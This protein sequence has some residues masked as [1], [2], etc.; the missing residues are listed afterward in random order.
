VRQS[1]GYV[2]LQS[3]TGEGATFQVY[4]PLVRRRDK[5]PRRD[6]A[7]AKTHFAGNE[8]ILLVDDEDELREAVAE[9][10]EGR[11]YKVLKAKDGQEAVRLAERCDGKISLLISDVVMPK[12]NG[13][14]LVDYIRGAHQETAVLVVSGYAD[15]EALRQGL[16]RTASFLQK[17]FTLQLLGARVRELMDEKKASPS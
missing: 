13:R 14:M 6:E 11:G 9:Y 17:P 12:M 3:T 2:T 15:D 16:S 1:G 5:R 10:L 4:L 8:T 7:A